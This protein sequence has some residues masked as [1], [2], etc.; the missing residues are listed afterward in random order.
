MAVTQRKCALTA[1]ENGFRLKGAA[2]ARAA[3]RSR[4]ISRYLSLKSNLN[5][6]LTFRWNQ[7]T[8]I[9]RLLFL[10]A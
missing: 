4:L 8:A 6:L 9:S 5:L 2:K 1:A 10:Q 3:I 7:L